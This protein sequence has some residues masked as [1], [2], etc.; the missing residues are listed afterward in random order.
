MHI[1]NFLIS[2][3][4]VNSKVCLLIY[5]FVWRN[6]LY[7]DGIVPKQIVPRE[8]PDDYIHGCCVPAVL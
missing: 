1:T 6:G 3:A 5:E 8:L 7:F 4:F 2:C